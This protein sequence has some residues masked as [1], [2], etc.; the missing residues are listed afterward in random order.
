VVGPA[1]GY[2]DGPPVPTV[3]E[4][5]EG[6]PVAVPLGTLAVGAVGVPAVVPVGL[7]VSLPTPV[8]VVVPG[9]VGLPVEVL[10]VEVVG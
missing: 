10:P 5:E 7:P 9:A 2:S 6:A 8:V 3:V 4:V 1:E